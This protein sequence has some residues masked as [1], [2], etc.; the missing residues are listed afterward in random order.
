MKIREMTMSDY[1]GVFELWDG[2]EGIGLSEA[3][4]PEGIEVYLAQ[5]K[6]L[7]LVAEKEEQIIAAVLAGHDGRRGFIHHL[8]VHPDYQGQ[9]I[10]SKMVK[11]C[12]QDLKAIGI[13]KCHIFLIPDNQNGYD[14]WIHRGFY[15]RKDLELM[16]VDLI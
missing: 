2:M 13:Q 5:N 15:K 3:D 9:G 16:S 1:P 4:Q 10:G 6:G 7:S 12:L 8:A 11:R 14:F